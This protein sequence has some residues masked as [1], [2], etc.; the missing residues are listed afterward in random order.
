MADTP[1]TSNSPAPP[2]AAVP[3]VPAASRPW[4]AYACGLTWRGYQDGALAAFEAAR[5]GFRPGHARFHL[6]APPGA[7]KTMM[8]L[9]MAARLGGPAVVLAP[10][11]TIQGQWLTKLRHFERVLDDGPEQPRGTARVPG[12]DKDAPSAAD[13]ALIAL[14]YQRIAV[15]KDGARH[16]RT[17][18]TFAALHAA[19]VRTVVLDECH[20]LSGTWG[21]AAGALIGAL[22]QSGEAVVVIALT[23][24]PLTDTTATYHDL[25]GAADYTISQPS[26]VKTGDLAPYQDL[27][28]ITAPAADE[29][30]LLDQ[31][32]TRIEQH[33]RT[34]LHPPRPEADPG[35]PAEMPSALVAVNAE[36]A[37]WLRMP[38][39]TS[40]RAYA[41]VLDFAQA[42]SELVE[43]CARVLLAD[44]QDVP[45]LLPVLP[46]YTDPP[47]LLD[48]V[49]VLAHYLARHALVHAPGQAWVKT[50]QDDV[51]DWGQKASRGQVR[52]VQSRLG[53]VLG[54]SRQ[55]LTALSAI[56]ATEQTHM[57][58]ELRVLVLT[59][60]ENPPDGRAA[61]SCRDVMRHLTT[62]AHGDALDPVMLT[63]QSLWVDDD[64]WPAV[65]DHLAAVCEAEGLD[66][67][68]TAVLSVADGG[69]QDADA[70]LPGL[71][72]VSGTGRDF[73]SRT[74]VRLVTALFEA[75]L[76]RCIVGTRALLGEGWDTVR[77]NTLVDL[78]AVTSGVSVNQMRGRTLRQDPDAALKVANNWDILCFSPDV[79]ALDLERLRRRHDVWY[80]LTDDG[81]I[82]PGIGHV[83]PFFDHADVADLARGMDR[84][85]AE[86]HARAADRQ[87][88]W[89]GW[90]IGSPFDDEDVPVLAF[91]ARAPRAPR[92]NAVDAALVPAADA[93]GAES[94]ALALP[95][96][97]TAA[98][99]AGSAQRTAGGFLVFGA[100]LAVLA[101]VPVALA[102][103]AGGILLGVFGAK[104]RRRALAAAPLDDGDELRLLA[105]LLAD[106]MDITPD[107]ADGAAGFDVLVRSDGTRRLLCRGYTA[108]DSARLL[109][110]LSEL[111][112]PVAGQRYVLVETAHA[113]GAGEAGTPRTFVVPRALASRAKAE[114]LLA[115]WQT[116]RDPGARL[117]STRTAEGKAHVQAMF[118]SAPHA[119]EAK[120]SRAWR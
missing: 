104:E 120:L 8:G 15:Q 43:A 114:A 57:A 23:A 62:D 91:R 29:S 55:K 98:E 47:S 33:W 58:D 37:A 73:N 78:T 22:G 68:L 11:A 117:L 63:G 100:T 109:G 88:A 12:F 85:N 106:A 83:H 39:T 49:L 31:A 65:R 110:A 59:D 96:R 87:S 67:A 66:V 115:A 112:G 86:M 18:A 97:L 16:P 75:G 81:E 14:T 82:A 36:V 99:A 4:A 20:H 71:M 102:M 2:C 61:L 6:V 7:G 35:A 69:A 34:A 77:L 27:I 32:R 103:L 53:R 26:V 21:E 70:A 38:Q 118:G 72:Q 13:T 84:I 113:P 79:G 119:A 10:N 52:R 90:A 64:A 108:A 5:A 9:E 3:A 107:D 105:G 54:H 76:C 92:A 101:S 50:M 111:L 30:A 46:A 25:L 24:T 94:L 116:A 56:L 44:G 95:A 17:D 40:G 93:P 89:R 74:I 80:G 45:A 1:D 19:G 48:R 28:H 51:A 41:D 42:E 60:Y